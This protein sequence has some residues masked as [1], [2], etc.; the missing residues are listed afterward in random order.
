MLGPSTLSVRLASSADEREVARFAAAFDGPVLL[1]ETRRF[2]SDPRHVVLLGYV[3]GQ[4]AGF[5]SAV[6][7]FHPDKR[8]ELFL[9]EIAVV[10]A[11]RRLGVG[12]ALIGELKRQ[13]EQRGCLNI[14]VLTDEG[15]EGAMKL[16]GKTG[17]IWDG[18]QQVMFEYPVSRRWRTCPGQGR[19]RR[20]AT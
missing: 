12:G 1:E 14:W 11:Q 19:G 17:G 6:E 5:L 10:E 20:P 7:V 16:Y 9:N 15:N 4:P 18:R 13:A 8:P 2:L 3:D